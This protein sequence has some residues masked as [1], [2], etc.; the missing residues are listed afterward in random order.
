MTTFPPVPG[1]TS[2]NGTVFALS[3]GARS[4]AP[5]ASTPSGVVVVSRA[6]HRLLDSVACRL[7]T[8]VGNTCAHAREGDAITPGIFS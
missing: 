8:K 1:P 7:R 6:R 5:H 2:P 4:F 3:L